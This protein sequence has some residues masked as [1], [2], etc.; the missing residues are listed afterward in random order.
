MT[1]CPECTAM[2]ATDPSCQYCLG[3][4]CVVEC[5]D[6]TPAKCGIY[7]I[8]PWDEEEARR[9]NVDIEWISGQGHTLHCAQ[10]QVWGD[11][12]CECRFGDGYPGRMRLPGGL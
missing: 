9:D 2:G 7:E 8:S 6:L 10:R 5:N 4:G 1:P 11:G 3:R 12:E